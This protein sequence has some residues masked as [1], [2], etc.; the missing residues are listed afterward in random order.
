MAAP[1]HSRRPGPP[2]SF[3]GGDGVPPATTTETDAVTEWLKWHA[4]E[5]AGIGVPVLLALAFSVWLVLLAVPAAALWASHG[6]RQARQRSQLR[7]AEH[8]ELTSPATGEETE[9]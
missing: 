5:L 6:A 4:V 2:P 3:G 8:D 9:S 1:D 7:G